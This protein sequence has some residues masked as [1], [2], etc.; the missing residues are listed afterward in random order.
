MNKPKRKNIDKQLHRHNE[1]LNKA[2]KWL[3]T[4]DGQQ[5]IKAYKKHF[6]VDFFAPLRNFKS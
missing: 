4:Y 5:I 1:H 6:R 2:K 3:P